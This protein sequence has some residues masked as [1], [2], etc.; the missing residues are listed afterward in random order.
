[1]GPSSGIDLSIHSRDVADAGGL[2]IGHDDFETRHSAIAT[3]RLRE[4]EWL[5]AQGSALRRSADPDTS[6]QSSA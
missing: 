6:F 3:A 2:D 5:A 1:M 4:A